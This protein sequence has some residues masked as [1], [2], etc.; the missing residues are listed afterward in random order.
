MLPLADNGLREEG[1]R[2]PHR[3]KRDFASMRPIQL[4]PPMVVG[5]IEVDLLILNGFTQNSRDRDFMNRYPVTAVS[6]IDR[7]L[8]IG[9]SVKDQRRRSNPESRIPA[10]AAKPFDDEIEA[11]NEIA[12]PIPLVGVSHGELD[13]PDVAVVPG[14][15]L[16]VSFC[17]DDG[18]K[19]SVKALALYPSR[20]AGTASSASTQLGQ[21]DRS[22]A[23]K[24]HDLHGK[25][26]EAYGYHRVGL[27]ETYVHQR[28]HYTGNQNR[29]CQRIHKD[30]GHVSSVQRQNDCA[31]NRKVFDTVRVRPHRAPIPILS[32][33]LISPEISD[34]NSSGKNPAP[35]VHADRR[36]QQNHCPRG[37]P[38]QPPYRHS[39]R[40]ASLHPCIEYNFMSKVR[41]SIHRGNRNVEA[42]TSESH[43]G[44]SGS[45]KERSHSSTSD[46]QRLIHRTDPNRTKQGLGPIRAIIC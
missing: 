16:E 11:D 8:G 33:H 42:F 9:D 43:H 34:L 31:K 35:P 41:D 28:L 36:G 12:S 15:L 22:Q 29:D 3:S 1:L 30:A 14:H 13:P 5:S 21:Q 6:P 39:H 38:E 10:D 25:E 17:L 27:N 19:C 24:A 45:A 40:S 18:H 37:E 46:V 7:N 26:P 2:K 20:S 4:D 32:L 23:Q 44:R